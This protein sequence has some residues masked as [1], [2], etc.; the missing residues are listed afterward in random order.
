M[1]DGR[2][3]GPPDLRRLAYFSKSTD[4]RATP[5]FVGRQSEIGDIENA[6]TQAF[7][8]FTDGVP[9]PAGGGTRLIYGAPGAGK[10]A[11]LAHL[12]TRWAAAEDAAPLA[13]AIRASDLQDQERLARRIVQVADPKTYARLRETKATGS[14]G[15]IGISVPDVK[16]SHRQHHSVSHAPTTADEAMRELDWKRPLALMIDEVQ[17][18]RTHHFEL[19][20]EY[21]LGTHGC[22]IVPVFAGLGISRQVLRGNGFSRMSES[23]THSLGCLEQAEAAEAVHRMLAEFR[24]ITGDSS[25]G[26]NRPDWPGL[27]AAK[28]DGWP[29]HLHN[30]MRTLAAALVKTGGHLDA[31]DPEAV[32]EDGRRMRQNHY[33]FLRGGELAGAEFLLKAVLEVLPREGAEQHEVEDAIAQYVQPDAGKGWSLPKNMDESDFFE[34][35]V[36]RGVLQETPDVSGRL[37]CP[38]PSFRDH[39]L[40]GTQENPRPDLGTRPYRPMS[41]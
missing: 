15:E 30:G 13:V 27:L 35:M 28:S 2:R 26:S 9:D 18:L 36:R 5:F 3:E 41:R 22:P 40:S 10:T 34:L 29:M 31:V 37:V 38:I 8:D 39:L 21:H 4:R 19:L 7:Q 16:A 24:V 23:S 12:R 17:D 11:L 1:M 32:L 20:Q 6:L 25:P 14:D 33:E